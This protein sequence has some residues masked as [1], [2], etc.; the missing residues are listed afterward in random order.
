MIQPT[1]NTASKI[2]LARA[3]C[4]RPTSPG[5]E[6]VYAASHRTR[7]TCIGKVTRRMSA[8]VGPSSHTEIGIERRQD[9]PA[10]VRGEHHP[11]AV[12]AVGVRAREQA[13]EEVR[14]RREDVDDAHHEAGAR[15]AQHEQRHRG[16]RDRV[17]EARDALAEED[18]QEVAVLAQRLDRPRRRHRRRRSQRAARRR[19]RRDRGRCSPREVTA[20]GYVGLPASPPPAGPIPPGGMRHPCYDWD[21]TTSHAETTIAR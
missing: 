17:A 4:D 12:P 19:A 21:R 8:I 9:R 20:A 5:T 15:E 13:D 2:A 1:L 7:S 16:A 11:P 18:G 6:A 10:E 14:E 3:T